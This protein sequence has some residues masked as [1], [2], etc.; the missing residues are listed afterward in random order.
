MSMIRNALC[1]MMIAVFPLSLMA[2]D[3][4]A[5]MLYARGSAWIN[6]STVPR[7]SAIFPGDMVQTQADSMANINATGS[8]V[9]ILSDSLVK[10]EGDAVSLEHGGVS[11]ATS[12]GMMTRA[13]EVT[14]A[15][16]STAWTEFE[17]TDV[18]G[19]VQIAAHIGDVSISDGSG[20]SS[21][22]P[23]G[24]ETTR[25]ESQT[26]QKDK[27]RG[28]AAAPAAT[29]GILDTTYAKWLGV[30]AVS[31]LLIWV[32]LQ[33]DEPLSPSGPQN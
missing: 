22:L 19:T 29:R 2:T 11:I 30:G 17:V 25:D 12:K 20:T 3:S 32:L 31:G 23:Q 33:G 7:S 8:N 4:G 16:A 6:G 5:A 14:V 1:W 24:E 21:T 28:G 9:M 26:Q 10:F 13:G 15:P 27:R 18:N